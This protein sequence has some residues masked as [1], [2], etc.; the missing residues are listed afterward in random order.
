MECNIWELAINKEFM[1]QYEVMYHN[2]TQNFYK[3]AYKLKEHNKKHD[4]Y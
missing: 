3:L 1:M 2:A 4:Q